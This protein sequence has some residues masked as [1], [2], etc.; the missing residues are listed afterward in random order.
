MAAAGRSLQ[1][2]CRAAFSLA[3]ATSTSAAA[4]AALAQLSLRGGAAAAAAYSNWGGLQQ[5]AAAAA[6]L[7]QLARVSEQRNIGAGLTCRPACCCAA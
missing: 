1:A 5:H 7:R 2:L 6:G 4:P 3:S